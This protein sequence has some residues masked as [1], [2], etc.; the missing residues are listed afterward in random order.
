VVFV[1]IQHPFADLRN[2]LGTESGRLP[3]PF[4]PL[5]EVGEDFIRSSGIVRPRR[6]GGVDEWAGEELYADAAHALRF[7]N[8]LGE[9][10]FGTGGVKAIVERSF[11]RFHSDGTV[12]RLDV[13]FRL[14][15]A[16]ST[17][18]T[19]TA[20]D[21]FGLL[22]DMLSIPVRV[23]NAKQK[24]VPDMKQKT[25]S[26]VELVRAGVILAPHYLAATTGRRLNYQINL[27]PWWFCSGNPA[28]FVEYPD[29]YPA[30]LPM[31]TRHVLDV[32]EAKAKV[33]HAWLEFN[34]KRVSAWF[35]SAGRGDPDT[36]RRL[37]IHLSRLHAERECLRLV[38]YHIRNGKFDL[39]KNSDIAVIQQY[40]NDSLR[41]IEKPKRFG[42]PQSAMLDAAQ[43]ALDI[44]FEG[45]VA[46]ILQTRRQV[47]AKVEDYIR[48]A[49]NTATVTYIGGNMTTITMSGVSVTGDFNLVTAENIQ[50]SFNKAAN[51][52]V[53]I[54]LKEK[55]KSLAVEV[56]NLVAKLPPADAEIVSQDL[57]SLTS[58]AVSKEPRKDRLK[59][60]AD[61]I[62][63]TAK[64]V[65]EVTMP[66]T[67][68]V[69][70]VL[71]L[72]AV[73]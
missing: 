50:N 24:T 53:D 23:P 32:P 58:A 40:I 21:W 54:E 66:V 65:A 30:P 14:S 59:F 61:S 16:K 73:I 62:M 67:A 12:A 51:A 33:S 20:V 2:F 38:L 1:V 60:F 7:P 22:R 26:M 18:V 34:E 15:I 17:S 28:L 11:R 69:K 71:A 70:A 39:A 37:R 6:R 56:A 48:R 72:L 42:L 27:H 3:H 13:G 47:A 10:R 19:P 29:R 55:L 63:E 49:Q 35:V 45:T 68:A 5:A 44:A 52:E 43:H 64:A 41:A 9:A 25:Q 57:K 46:S 4:W 8:H 36:V 31:H